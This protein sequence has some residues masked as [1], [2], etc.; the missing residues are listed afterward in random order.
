MKNVDSKR[1]NKR[2]NLILLDT[3]I[4]TLLGKYGFVSL[5]CY[6]DVD[7]VQGLLALVR[8]Y[9]VNFNTDD[10]IGWFS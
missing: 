8:R 1:G 9:K 3:H 7:P 4:R 10:G 5:L 6:L 2:D